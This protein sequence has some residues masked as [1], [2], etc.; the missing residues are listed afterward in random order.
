[1]KFISDDGKLVGTEQDVKAYELEQKREKAKA[2]AAKAAKLEADKKKQEKEKKAKQNYDNDVKDLESTVKVINDIFNRNQ[3][4][5]DTK[6]LLFCDGKLSVIDW[7]WKEYSAKVWD[8]MFKKID[9]K[10][11]TT[12]EEKEL[13]AIDD[14]YS[15]LIK[16]FTSSNKNK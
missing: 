15:D 6:I 1:M 9:N 3:K 12:F 4:V 5:K 11:Y 16:F 13:K 7:D 10:T 14:I 8:S 2:D